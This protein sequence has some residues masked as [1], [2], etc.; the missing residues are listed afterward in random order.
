MRNVS[1]EIRGQRCGDLEEQTPA[2]HSPGPQVGPGLQLSSIADRTASLDPYH[3]RDHTF[4]CTVVMA[5]SACD[6]F[7]RGEHCRAAIRESFLGGSPQEAADGGHVWR[8]T[9]SMRGTSEDQKTR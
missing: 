9:A 4:G 1:T 7:D 3:D 6:H 2:A 5:R 8:N